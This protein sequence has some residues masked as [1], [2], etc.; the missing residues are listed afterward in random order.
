MADGA[1]ETARD[2][3]RARARRDVARDAR[4]AR[5][6]HP[7]V[8]RATGPRHRLAPPPPD[9]YVAPAKSRIQSVLTAL[10]VLMLV[11]GLYLFYRG[12]SAQ[13]HGAPIRAESVDVRGAFSGLSVVRS[14][15][16]GRHY[17]WFDD[18][19]RARGAR[20]RPVWREAL[21]ELSPGESISLDLAPT[22]PGS[23]TLWAWRVRTS[24]GVTLVD[25]GAR[26]R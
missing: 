22:V 11:A 5:G 10:P 20:I 9:A 21:E 26:L 17:L 4:A 1:D 16:E 6:A 23:T 13:S 24:A 19:T 8:R 15:A 25:D 2:A 7:G 18:G 3:G 12:E 14:G